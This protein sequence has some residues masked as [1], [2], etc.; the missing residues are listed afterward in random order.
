M[1]G[2]RRPDWSSARQ[3]PELDRAVRISGCHYPAVRAE[4]NAGHP[5]RTGGK[6]RPEERPV[7]ARA[8][9]T[10]EQHRI[11]V[12]AGSQDRTARAEGDAV[13]ATVALDERSKG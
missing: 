11:P 4:C 7:S 6:R 3:I 8:S 13:Q 10:P 1:P 2:E 12:A 5:I 9:H